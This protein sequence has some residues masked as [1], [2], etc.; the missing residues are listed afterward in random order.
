MNVQTTWEKMH[1]K[2]H[3][4]AGLQR[5]RGEPDS[6][7]PRKLAVSPRS[8]GKL[9]GGVHAVACGFG[10]HPPHVLPHRGAA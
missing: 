8:W 3:S 4:D 7:P 6:L 1:L 10:R 9:T 2:L 5:K